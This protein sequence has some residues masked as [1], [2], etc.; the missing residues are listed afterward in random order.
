MLHWLQDLQSSIQQQQPKIDTLKR[1]T[2]TLR[3][4]VEN[5]RPGLTHHHDLDTIEKDVEDVGARWDN[6]CIQVVERCDSCLKFLK[7]FE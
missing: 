7:K 3:T 5:S 2:A 4:L 6:V 1:D